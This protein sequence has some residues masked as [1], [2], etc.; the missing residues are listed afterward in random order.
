[1]DHE[2]FPRAEEV[3][4]LL[5][6][7]AG[8]ARLYPPGSALIEQA[9]T[10]FTLR[11]NELVSSGPF[12]FTI[13]PHAFRI[14]NTQLGAGHGPV[15]SLA[16]TLY[17]MQI[18]MLVI[19]PGV[20]EVE[21][22]TF[23]AVVNTDVATV[24]A[25]GGARSMLTSHGVSHMAVIEVTL[26]ASEESGLLGLDLTTA[27]ME[28]IAKELVE[29][30]E[31]RVEEAKTGD[32]RDE[33][34]EA[35]D[36][37]E[38]ATREI[39]ME[40]VATAMMRLDERSRQRVL[41]MSLFA[42]KSG[43]RMSGMLDVIAHMRPAALSRLLMLVAQQA[44][45]DARRLAGALDLPPQTARLLLMSLS[46][47]TDVE[48]DF[49]MSTEEQAEKIADIVAIEDDPEATASRLVGASA[50]ESS[51]RA[52]ATATAVSRH[53]LDAE[54]IRAFGEVLPQAARD[55]S[56]RVVRE[57]L[58]RLDEIALDSSFAVDVAAARG[59][60]ARPEVL[61]DVCATPENDADAAIAG[62]ILHAS[63]AV[64]AEVLLETYPRLPEHKRSLF[65]PVMRTMSEALLGVAGLAL[66]SADPE[67]AIAII[68]T[69]PHLGD[70]RAVPVIIAGLSSL[71]ERTRFAAATALASMPVPE[72]E[73]ALVR[74]VGHR[75]PETQRHVIRELGRIRAH[76][77]V[78]ALGRA[79]ED[80]TSRNRTY[81]IRKEIISA[82]ANIGT[83]E[84]ERTLRR[85][86]QRTVGFRKKTR[87]LKKYAITAA[88]QLASTRGVDQ[89]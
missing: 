70:R 62:E 27:P 14:G 87:E 32:A 35:L 28:D 45:T 79:L 66:R 44:G 6:S 67:S 15:V 33:M 5:A 68:N 41:A 54:T 78:P 10:R 85:Y 46:P 80:I 57:A 76:S 47:K 72:S 9:T 60:L 43:N 82:L 34:R 30:V 23:V 13:E 12:R 53:R 22:E 8:A 52:L 88:D 31:R 29:A 36:R 73:A 38:D 7:A 71:D 19:A 56:F 89:S 20:T 50:A 65:R 61:R 26:K 49:G 74:A 59:T 25:A 18:G 81:E 84:A 17:A 11:S 39:A 69:L 16:E 63:G 2:S 40:R 42:D 51:T 83:A 55:G 1:M 86:A 75:E 3:L 77:A 21:T 48:P 64:G 24:R 37:L 4:R 58:R